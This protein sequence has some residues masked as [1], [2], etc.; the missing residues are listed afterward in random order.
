MYILKSSGV[1]IWFA[2]IFILFI[3]V[4]IECKE[5][6]ARCASIV[7]AEGSRATGYMVDVKIGC[8]NFN[9]VHLL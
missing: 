4:E 6:V 9:L 3:G 7:T 8:I 1:V 5:E 2:F